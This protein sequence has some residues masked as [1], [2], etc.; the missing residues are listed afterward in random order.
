MGS[1]GVARGRALQCV[2]A[3]IAAVVAMAVVATIALH[4]GSANAATDTAPPVLQALTVD[5]ATVDVTNDSGTVTVTATISDD[6][7]GVAAQGTGAG[8]LSSLFYDSTSGN[9]HAYGTLVHAGGDQYLA[10]VTIPQNA[11]SGTW[12]L[13]SLS[14]YDNAGNSSYLT[15]DLLSGFDASFDVTASAPSP[16]PTGTDTTAPTLQALSV[17]PA[18]IDVST[19]SAAVTF[20]ATITDD[21]SGVASNCS[22]SLGVR[23]PS[24]QQ[25]AGGCLNH[26][27]GNTWIETIA[28]PRYAEGGTWSISYLNLSDKVGNRHFYSQTD[29]ANANF[30]TFDVQSGAPTLESTPASLTTS[31]SAS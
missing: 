4:A 3:V 14:L 13:N 7:S 23:S 17:T 9:Q 29:L 20:K 22:T 19:G 25:S 6:L 15:A 10:E 28:I 27:S 1:G 26:L 24:G 5:P 30:P 21:L 8:F 2:R 16:P 11:E 31:T 18:S 12:H